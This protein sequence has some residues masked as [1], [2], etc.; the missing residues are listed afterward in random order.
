M[1]NHMGAATCLTIGDPT[2]IGPEIVVKFLNT[3]HWRTHPLIV[4]G[5]IPGLQET[6]ER[7]N[8]T[9]PEQ[10]GLEYWNVASPG[11][12]PGQVAYDALEEAVKAMQA[13]QASALVTGPISKEN[14]Q[15]AGI[16]FS[17]HTEILQALARRYYGQPCQSDMLFVY[18][19]FRMLLLTRHIPLKRVHETLTLKGVMQSMESLII[20]LKDQAGIEKP[21]LCILGVNPHAGELEGE[22]EQR[23]LEPAI[24]ELN[25]KYD[26]EIQ[27]PVAAD[28]A[29]RHF[30]VSRLQHDAYVAAYHDQGL[31]PFKMVAGMEAVNVTIGLPFLRT[32]VSHGTAPDIV[33]QGVADPASL[34]TAYQTALSFSLTSQAKS[35]N[36]LFI[37]HP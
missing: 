12:A 15:A 27:P 32:S 7:L 30:D 35:D 22:E 19:G 10:D 17:G 9:L 26:L 21:R 33:G 6:A 36:P 2:G 1:S 3:E 25:R 14:L 29:F 20:F 24:R 37:V 31:I 4:L 34:V 18:H 28:A 5:D 16:N 23:F 13:G 8:L 11:K